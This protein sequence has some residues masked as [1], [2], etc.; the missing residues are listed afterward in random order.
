MVLETPKFTNDQTI[1][2]CDAIAQ[3]VNQTSQV[4][5]HF[6]NEAKALQRQA[7]ETLSQAGEF[8]RNKTGTSQP[9]Q[10]ISAAV[11]TEIDML[12]T[13]ASTVDKAQSTASD[14]MAAAMNAVQATTGATAGGPAAEMANLE[15]ATLQAIQGMT[16][17]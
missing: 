16:S 4:V 1:A 15:Q 3:A 6:E 13:M 9:D 10:A 12:Q 5:R 2:G 11:E 7:K 17:Q 14:S 8:F